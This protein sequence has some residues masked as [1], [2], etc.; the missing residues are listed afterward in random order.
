MKLC[1][2]SKLGIHST[3][4]V[5]NDLLLLSGVAAK[6]LY[7]V[8]NAGNKSVNCHKGGGLQG[9]IDYLANNTPYE[10]AEGMNRY[11]YWLMLIM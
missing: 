9:G 8:R 7:P 2:A 3:D 1:K 5:I 6:P 10:Y 4:A 11:F